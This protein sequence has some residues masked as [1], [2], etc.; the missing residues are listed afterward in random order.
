MQW[1]LR[2][3]DDEDKKLLDKILCELDDERIEGGLPILSILVKH[4]D[5]SASTV[6]WNTVKKH[7]L[8][9]D[10]K[11]NAALIDRFTKLAFARPE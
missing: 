9:L 10:G 3:I 1:S 7:N 11:D 8:R 6:F 5:G 4:H 2:M